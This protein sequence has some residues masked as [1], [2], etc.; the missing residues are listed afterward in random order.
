MKVSYTWLKDHLETTHP[1]E[2]L[3]HKLEEIAFEVDWVSNPRQSLRDITVAEIQEVENHPQADKLHVCRV[4]DGQKVLQIVCGAPNVYKGMKTALVHVGGFVPI[5]GETLKAAKIRG[6]ESQAMM[7]SPRELQL[8]DEHEGILDITKQPQAVPGKSL[9]EVLGLDDPIV[10]VGIT[11]NRGDCLSVRGLAR[12]LAAAGMGTLKPLSYEQFGIAKPADLA[13]LPPL[14]LDVQLESPACDLFCGCVLENLSVGASPEW[15]QQRLQ[16]AGQKS[17]NALVDVTNFLCFDLGQP[18]H[19]YDRQTLKGGL[20][21]RPA[22][23]G[24]SLELLNDEKVSLTERDLVIADE[25]APLILA[26]V[27]GGKDSG[28]TESTTQVLLEAAHFDAVSITFSG[29]RHNLRSESRARFERGIDAAQ[30]PTVLAWA[31]ALVQSLCGGK[32]VG[33]AVKGRAGRPAHTITLTKARLQGLSGEASLSLSTAAQTLTSLGFE[34]SSCDESALTAAVPSWRNDVE[35]DG[36][37]MEE[38]LRMRGYSQLAYEPLPPKTGTCRL[39]PIR[40]LKTTLCARGLSEVYTLPFCSAAECALFGA[41]EKA[42]EVLKPLN[43]EMAFLRPSLMASLLKVVAYNKSRQALSGGI[44]EFESAF[45]KGPD[46]QAPEEQKVL[47]GIRFGSTTPNWL[48]KERSVD[49]FDVKADL[50]AL[51]ETCRLNSYQTKTEGL[52]P[53]YHPYKSGL[54]VRGREVLGAFGELHPRVAKAFDLS[55]AVEIFELFVTESVTSKMG[56]T[57]VQPLNLSPLQPMTRD[58]AFLLDQDVP[59]QQLVDL[60]RKADKHIVEVLVFDLYEGDQVEAGKKSVAVK[61][62]LQPGQQTFTD[63]ALQAMTNT[64][65]SSVERKLQGCLR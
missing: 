33:A 31:V 39:D 21:I 38:I 24:E 2:A 6:V 54:F 1:M 35:G 22:R 48:E 43:S 26:G 46:P 53:Y 29:Q 28:S 4:F 9:V 5:L 65:T 16:V 56:K 18:M 15:M 50:E 47:A 59:V 12:E 63:E 17:I 61:V 13:T 45:L 52:P 36:D 64:I 40:K 27:M 3:V 32:V 49:V 7:C 42:V 60:I 55:G 51:L 62:R 37:L 57:D 11:P 30:T 34:V 8:S 10:D 25:S 19:A 14:P 58:F 44:F 23:E 41:E 20:H